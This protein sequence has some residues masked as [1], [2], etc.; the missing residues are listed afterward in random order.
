MSQTPPILLTERLILRPFGSGD[1][2]VWNSVKRGHGKMLLLTI[3]RD[4]WLL[5]QV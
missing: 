3:N 4:E 2:D 1:V 5:N